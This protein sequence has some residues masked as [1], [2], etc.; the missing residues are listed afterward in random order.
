MLMRRRL[1]LSLALAL[2]AWPTPGSAQTAST[3]SWGPVVDGLRLGLAVPDEESA[4]PVMEVT[5]ENAG[6]QDVLL[7]VGFMLANGRTMVPDAVRLVVRG[8]SFGECE[9]EYGDRRVP[10]V[11]GR[12][13]GLVVGLPRTARYTV[14][15]SLRDFWCASRR[16]F[17]MLWPVE[18]LQLV[19]R[20]DGHPAGHVN[21]DTPGMRLMQF[22][23]GQVTSGAVTLHRRPGL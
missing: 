9:L 1:G 11:A 5:V 22:W 10:G 4:T 12:V 20:F 21:L 16:Q 13:D 18:T 17:P 19:A 8:P 7:N 3:P 6:A 15:L 14:S 23:R 2:C